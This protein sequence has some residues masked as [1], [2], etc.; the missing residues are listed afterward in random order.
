[1][2][3]EEKII[4]NL[5]EQA[6]NEKVETSI[7]DIRKWIGWIT[8]GTILTGLLTK[9]KV[10]FT[11]SVIMYSTVILTAGIGLGT[12]FLYGTGNESAQK[13]VPADIGK[14]IVQE[15][16]EIQLQNELLPKA[17]AN[18]VHNTVV[19]PE[20]PDQEQP[21]GVP[22]MTFFPFELPVRN[23]LPVGSPAEQAII[24]PVAGDEVYGTFNRLKI[25]GAVDV[26]I[27]QGTKESVKV[28][29]DEK[30]KS[31][32]VI[33]NKNKT[34][35][36]YTNNKKSIK[37]FRIKVFVTVADLEKLDLSGATNVSSAGE[38]K[39]DNLDMDVSGASNV[40]L[41]LAVTDLNITISGASEV[42]L[43]LNASKI[44]AD[45]HGASDVVLSGTASTLDLTCGGAC[46]L[47]AEKLKAR[48]GKIT[49]TGAS[50][51]KVHFSESL[52][53]DATGASDLRYNGNPK[54]GTKS[55]TGAAKVRQF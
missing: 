13:K 21:E 1:M 2:S 17:P 53:I 15:E 37:D 42:D 7:H 45:I 41:S 19:S 26:V 30:G 27:T 48:S 8:L 32:L 6:R 20:I 33:D 38:L 36:I 49:C 31:I 10:V 11:K 47:K 40:N 55:V 16:K 25:Y 23:P 29:A 50:S 34:L 3:R 44:N 51:S 9:M 39:S 12:F 54:I 18:T 43:K 4:N 14:G 35:E 46:D 24:R 52:D 28:E 22:E 5:F